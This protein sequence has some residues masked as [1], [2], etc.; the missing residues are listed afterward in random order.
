VFVALSPLAA[1]WRLLVPGIGAVLVV[2]LLLWRWSWVERLIGWLAARAGAE[3][4]LRL[5]RRDLMILMGGYIIAWIGGGCV[6][7]MLGRGVVPLALDQLPFII[8]SWAG[9]GV[10]SVVAQFAVGNMGLRELALATLLNA[11]LPLPAAVLISILFRL[12]LMIGE[13]SWSLAFA[14]AASGLLRWSKGA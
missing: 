14:G 9:A 7:F 12:L 3:P 2:G 4:N 13:V 6:L 11:A 8:A 10:V 5:R 1:D